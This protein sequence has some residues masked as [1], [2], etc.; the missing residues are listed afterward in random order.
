MKFQF[1]FALIVLIGAVYAVPTGWGGW[2]PGIAR[3]NT[4]SGLGWDSWGGSRTNLGWGRGAGVRY[5]T[6]N[7]GW[8]RG[9]GLWG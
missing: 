5:N 6:V 3:E 4:Y 7:L 1:I 2:G 9:W 8:N